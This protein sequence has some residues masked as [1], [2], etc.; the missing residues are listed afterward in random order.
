MGLDM[1]KMKFKGRSTV[2]AFRAGVIPYLMSTG[3]TLQEAVEFAKHAGFCVHEN[4]VDNLVVTAGKVLVADFLVGE[5]R[6]GLN[7]HAIGTNTTAPAA[8]DTQLGT[9][10][11]RKAFTSIARSSTSVVVS[12]FYTAAQSTFNIKEGGIFGNGA[13]AAADSGTLFSHFSQAEDNSAGENDL[14]FDCELLLR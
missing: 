5:T 13:T 7:Y 1:D 9:E 6:T 14:T 12:V 10:T 8:G 11:A 4:I 3:M 2:R